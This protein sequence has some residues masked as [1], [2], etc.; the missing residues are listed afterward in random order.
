MIWGFD[1]APAKD[2]VNGKEIRPSLDDHTTVGGFFY[3]AISS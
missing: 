3:P 2:P 1:F